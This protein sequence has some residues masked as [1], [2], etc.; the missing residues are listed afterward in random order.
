M[1]KKVFVDVVRE[2]TGCSHAA[3]RETTAA[4]IDAIAARLKKDGRFVLSGFG[5]F[6]VRKNRA[7]KGINPA[8]GEPIKIKS[9]KSVRFR[10]SKKLRERV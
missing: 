8:T 9:S 4:V 10:P 1:S 5:A 2:H 3:A 7:R 6:V